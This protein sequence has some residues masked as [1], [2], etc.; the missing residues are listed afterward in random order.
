[1][2]P[3]PGSISPTND[4]ALTVTSISLLAAMVADV[5][6][7]G[8]GHGA[9]ALITG[10]PSGLLTTVAW[11]SA[12]DSKL[13][14][15]GGTLANLAAGFVF[16]IAL[17]GTKRAPVQ[18]RFFLLVSG[19]FNLLAGTGYFFFSGVTNFGDWAVVITDLHPHWLWRTL[20]VVIGIAAY[21]VAVLVVGI[22]LVRYV[23]IP[24][25]DQRRL[26]R[27][28]LI[29]YFSAALLLAAGGLLNPIGI[30][31]VW[32]SALPGAAG[33][34]SGLLW[35]R[36]YIPRKTI[37]ERGSEGIGRNYVWITVA[38]IFSLVFIFVLGRGIT[39]HR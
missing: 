12:I 3:T 4:D 36:Y 21:Y 1:M 38:A 33:A 7:E 32:Q 17:R 19:A 34:H 31:L 37:P 27:L 20:L 13:V 23:G 18:L 14:A 6:H 5:I 25:A 8:L 28:T 24:R 29:P 26:R 15:A 30:Q 22:G 35:L 9:L 10:T 16:W 11:S 2:T 39:L